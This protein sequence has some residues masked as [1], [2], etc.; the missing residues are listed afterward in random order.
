M[1]RAYN[2]HAG[3]LPDLVLD[4][5]LYSASMEHLT[6]RCGHDL[7]FLG[8]GMEPAYQTVTMDGGVT[9]ISMMAITGALPYWS[10]EPLIEP[11]YTFSFFCDGGRGNGHGWIWEFFLSEFGKDDYSY[12]NSKT[13]FGTYSF[14]HRGVFYPYYSDWVWDASLGMKLGPAHFFTVIAD[15]ALIKLYIDGRL[16]MEAQDENVFFPFCKLG[17][18]GRHDDR[19]NNSLYRFRQF[20]LFRKALTPEEVAALYAMELAEFNA[21]ATTI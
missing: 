6:D 21:A 12:L 16:R 19:T 10:F 2:V 11:C 17:L 8:G 1:R 3:G 14:F 9:G 15:S 18:R 7:L 5:P 13:D 4:I 20:K